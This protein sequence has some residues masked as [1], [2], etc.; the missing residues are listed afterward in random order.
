VVDGPCSCVSGKICPSTVQGA[1]STCAGWAAVSDDSDRATTCGTNTFSPLPPAVISKIP[2]SRA[3]G[4][5]STIKVDLLVRLLR[6]GGGRVK[7]DDESMMVETKITSTRGIPKM[8]L[9]TRRALVKDKVAGAC[10]AT[11]HTLKV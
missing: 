2:V 7:S 6:F 5:S 10:P 11:W 1:E 4:V 8:L 3:S 9:T